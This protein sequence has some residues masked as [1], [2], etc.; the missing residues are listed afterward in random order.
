M[1]VF[2]A[3][4][5]WGVESVEVWMSVQVWMSVTAERYDV[6]EC[7]YGLWE[8]GRVAVGCWGVDE[9]CNGVLGCG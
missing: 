1:Q 3:K 5:C 2:V 4:W 8:C 9:C 7:C 6:D